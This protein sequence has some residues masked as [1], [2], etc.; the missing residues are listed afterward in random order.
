MADFP[1]VPAGYAIPLVDL[2]TYLLPAPTVAA[3]DA[4]YPTIADVTALETLTEQGR[5]S[6]DEL[7]ATFATT[8]QGAKADAA[9]PA[10]QKGAASGVAPLDGSSKVPVVN[11]PLQAIADSTELSATIGGFV[12]PSALPQGRT[13]LALGDSHTAGSGATNVAFSYTTVAARLVGTETVSVIR[14]GYAGERSDQLL[15]RLPGLLDLNAP[16]AVWVMCGT[17]DASQAI[18]PAVFIGNIASMKALCD[19]RGIPFIVGMVPPNGASATSPAAS[20]RISRVRAYNLALLSWAFDNAVVVA[21]EFAATVDPATG[22]MAE[23]YNS[24]DHIHF[25]N[26]GHAKLSAPM[27]SA[28]ARGAVLPPWPV[29]A[30]GNGLLPNPLNNSAL[31]GWSAVAGTPDPTSGFVPAVDGDGVT[32]GGW[33]QL[34]KDNSA[35]GSAYSVIRAQNIDMTDVLAGDVLECY[36]RYRVTGNATASLRVLRGSTSISLPVDSADSTP[37]SGTI[38][39]Y[40]VQAADIGQAMRWGFSVT[41][42]ANGIGSAACAQQDV[43]NRTKLGVI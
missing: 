8:A 9:I 22:Y 40:V 23:A 3:F 11:L 12:A 1:D 36:A 41:V 26:A 2:A 28:L 30:K 33:F 37:L 39:R 24:G 19:E 10:T 31:G 35:N 16:G 29:T 21:D 34:D 42:E 18:T 6:E 32:A 38:F 43:F 20:E 15:V 27:S 13:V 4:R 17:N 14:A 5:L 7:S 25:N